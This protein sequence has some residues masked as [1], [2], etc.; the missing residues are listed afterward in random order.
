VRRGTAIGQAAVVVALLA[1]CAPSAGSEG[2]RTTVA[3]ALYPLAEVA[4]SVGGNAVE[5]TDI[6]PPGAEPHDLEL[7]AEQVAEIQ[8]ADVVLYLGG[9][10]QPAVEAAVTEA[11]GRVVDLLEALPAVSEGS[12]VLDEHV[13]LDPVLMTDMT[14]R[15]ARAL[16]RADPTNRTTFR[17]NADAFRADLA[18]LDEAYREGLADCERRT[19]VVSHAAFHYLAERY[20]LRQEAISGL[21]PEAEPDPAR[22]AALADLVR[23]EGVTVVFTEELVSPE[24]AET[25][26]RE[27][28]VRTEIL[29]PLEGLTEEQSAAGA[30]YLSVMEENLAKLRAALGC[31]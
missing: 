19:I 17:A 11:Q 10:F 27:T 31:A 22:L 28:G 3:A 18:A 5:V 20:G 16:T 23:T 29:S 30:D 2:G 14:E 15:L 25:L 12:G 7:T 13:W 8:T 6:T 1:G 26:A 21:S 4:R 9:G 24:V